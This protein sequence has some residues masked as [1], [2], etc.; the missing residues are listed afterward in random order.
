MSTYI[1]GVED[2]IPQAKPFTP[3][4]KFLSDVLAIRQDRYDKN[5]KHLND[6]YG[7][8]V[9]ADLLRAENK[10]VRDQYAEQLS[11]RIKQL[12]GLDLSLQENVDAA[13]GLFKPFYE[14]EKII[15]DL[16]AS[17]TLKNQYNKM[18]SFKSSPIRKV[19]EQYW[20]YGKKGL[21]YWKE[22]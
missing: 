7:K 17:A 11:P 15:H 3:D 16:T 1:P 4:Y 13:Y 12:T 14:D 8:V 9:Y 2:Y 19:R 22:K 18:N 5:Y 20:D 6:I 10:N 21:D